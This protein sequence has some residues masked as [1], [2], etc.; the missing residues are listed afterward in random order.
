[1]SAGKTVHVHASVRL[2]VHG[3]L[4]LHVLVREKVLAHASV[5]ILL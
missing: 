5:H 2:R 3:C 4:F 1:M